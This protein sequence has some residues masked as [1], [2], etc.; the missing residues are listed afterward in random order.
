MVVDCITLIKHHFRNKLCTFECNKKSCF[1]IYT[2]L[3]D[4]EPSDCIITE[5]IGSIYYYTMM[6][7]FLCLYTP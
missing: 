3:L 4:S 5:R 2:I 1:G 6:C 7:L